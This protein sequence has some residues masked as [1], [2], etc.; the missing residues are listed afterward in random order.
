MGRKET[1]EV[2]KLSGRD[3]PK[4]PYGPISGTKVE[5]SVIVRFLA[6]S[7]GLVTKTNKQ[8]NKHTNKNKNTRINFIC[9]KWLWEILVIDHLSVHMESQTK[10]ICHSRRPQ[11]L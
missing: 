5:T 8:T 4:C 2:D 3:H 9:G 7:P 1:T 11:S 6:L 10:K